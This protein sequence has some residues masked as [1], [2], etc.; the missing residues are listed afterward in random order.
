M[1]EG[2]HILWPYIKKGETGKASIGSTSSELNLVL[3]QI[4]PS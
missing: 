4:W 2:L 1:I 3:V